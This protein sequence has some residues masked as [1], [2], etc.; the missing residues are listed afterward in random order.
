MSTIVF[1]F[2]KEP[3]HSEDRNIFENMF[4]TYLKTCLKHMRRRCTIL[5]L[6]LW[7]QTRYFPSNRRCAVQDHSGNLR[8][9]P[10]NN[11]H[12]FRE[13]S[14][15]PGE[16]SA[17]FQG[18]FSSIQGTYC[19]VSGKIRLRPGNIQPRSENTRLHPGNIQHR[20]GKIFPCPGNIKKS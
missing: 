12:R 20:L 4:E 5:V 9:R 1:V 13:H 3:F 8:L 19:T 15:A 6:P 18:T 16:H 11:Q 17:P 2:L 14:A 7:Q 10:R